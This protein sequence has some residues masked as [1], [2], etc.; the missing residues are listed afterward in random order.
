[1]F[2]IFLAVVILIGFLI[3]L[4]VGVF[5]S[6][7]SEPDR[8]GR[9]ALGSA[10]PARFTAAALAFLF[11]LLTI[12]FSATT[13]GA[14]AVGV[15]TAF[16]RYQNTLQ[17]GLQFTEPW[18]SVEEFSTQIQPLDLDGKEQSV[19]VNFA[20]GGQGNVDATVRWYIDTDNAKTLWEKY[21]TF[22]NVRDQLVASSAK[23]SFRVVLGKYTPND[24]RAGEN[25]R[26]ITE[27]VRADLSETLARY[28]V[29]VDS[30]SVKRVSLDDATQ[31]S[32]EKIVVANN[33]VERARSEQERAKIDAATAKIRQDGGSLTGPALIRQCLDVT[34]AWDAGRNG[35]LPAGWSCLGGGA[36]SVL[37]QQSQPK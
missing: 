16:G 1:L 17:S 32:L 14:R 3:A 36:N 24:A 10:R 26:P 8:Q 9:V 21:K 19:N 20:G 27:Q 22:D 34:N 30:I 13:V 25:L 23:D 2:Y 29:K 7:D 18:A 4:A 12:A 11:I 28:G 15:E 5:G 35:P 31:R 33:D 6:A 37:L